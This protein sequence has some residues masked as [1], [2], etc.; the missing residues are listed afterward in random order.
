MAQAPTTPDV[1]HAI[2]EPRRRDILTLLAEQGELGVTAIVVSLS[3][4][5]PAVS[6]HLAVL[7]EVGVV[8]VRRQGRER[9]YSLNAETLRVIH[10]WTRTFERFWTSQTDRIKARAQQAAPN[11]QPH[12][13]KPR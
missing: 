8:A 7:R 11:P 9:M 10:E 1:F 2:A 12:Q 4:P 5:Q 13:E 3:Q 6:K